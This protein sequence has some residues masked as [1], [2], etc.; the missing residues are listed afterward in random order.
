MR[1][2][3]CVCVGGGGLRNRLPVGSRRSILTPSLQP[4]NGIVTYMIPSNLQS[5]IDLSN[6]QLYLKSGRG[7]HI[8]VSP[9]QSYINNQ[10]N[11]EYIPAPER[12]MYLD[13]TYIIPFRTPLSPLEFSSQGYSGYVDLKWR[14]PNLFNDPNYYKTDI[15]ATYYQYKYFTLESRDVSAAQPVWTV[16]SNEISIPTPENGGVAGFQAQYTVS[17]LQNERPYQFR[18]RTVI[19]NEYIGQ[20]AESEYTYMSIINNLPAPDSSGVTVTPSIYPYKPSS[21]LLRFANRTETATGVTN[22]LVL[23]FDYPSYSGNAD[24]YEC[25]IYYTP[26]D[27]VWYGIFDVN[28]G[29]ADVSYNISVNSQLFTII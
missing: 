25:D 6:A 14:L 1:V 20:R 16:V 8:T 19:I 10:G 23:L 11:A 4:V 24:Y 5:D 9:V 17:N 12:N 3:V 13:G 26:V 7:Y 2:C 21:A 28:N 29:I 22:G 27:N 18:I 15:T